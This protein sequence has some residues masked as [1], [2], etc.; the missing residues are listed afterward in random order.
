M[1]AMNA[2]VWV[3]AVPMRM[4]SMN[5]LAILLYDEGHYA[6]AEKSYREVLGIYETLDVELRVWGPEHPGTLDLMG[7]LAVAIGREGRFAEAEKLE[8][9]T[10]KSQRRILGPESWD[11]ALSK[12]RLGCILLFKGNRDQALSLIRESVDHGLPS[13]EVLEYIERNPDL[14]S[15]HGDPRFAAIEADAKERAAAAQK[16]K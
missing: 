9:E 2:E 7:N 8:R 15:L 10:L 13:S 16:P 1:P 11:A 3:P 14:A 5:N 12:Y 4:G 6:E